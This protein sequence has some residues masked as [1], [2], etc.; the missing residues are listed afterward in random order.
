MLKSYAR[1]Q[2]YYNKLTLTG[3]GEL[4]LADSLRIIHRARQD[5][6]HFYILLDGL[7]ECDPATAAEVITKLRS[8]RNPP[9]M[10]AASR[11][12]P[13]SMGLSEFFSHT[14]QIQA[15]K[16]PD[17]M[18]S[19]VNAELTQMELF[20]QAANEEKQYMIQ[21]VVYRCDSR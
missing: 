8:L 20:R 21:M 6:Q 12:S 3:E 15:V 14:I 17:G 7:D 1:L 19:F 4:E 11:A 10:L 16:D 18:Q 2:K 9:A 5:F 13:T